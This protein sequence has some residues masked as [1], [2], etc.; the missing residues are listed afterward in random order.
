MMG[1]AGFIRSVDVTEAI[2]LDVHSS[3][4]G[5]EYEPTEVDTEVLLRGKFHRGVDV[6]A[7]ESRNFFGPYGVSPA[8]DLGD[9]PILVQFDPRLGDGLAAVRSSRCRGHGR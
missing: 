3:K 5:R 2:D 7:T 4:T 8:I 9:E 1:G 6:V